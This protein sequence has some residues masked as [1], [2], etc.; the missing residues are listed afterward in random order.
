M[1]VVAAYP[2]EDAVTGNRLHRLTLNF[3]YSLFFLHDNAFSFFLS[4][5][6]SPIFDDLFP[7]TVSFSAP[8]G[9]HRRGRRRAV[10]RWWT[11]LIIRASLSF[12]IFM[13]LWIFFFV[14]FLVYQEV[15]CCG[16]IAVELR[17]VLWSWR[18][19]SMFWQLILVGTFL[20][21][22]NCVLLLISNKFSQDLKVGLVWNNFDG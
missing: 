20:D 7:D 2:L 18:N 15:K 11:L 9:P 1:K 3:L 16:F 12:G 21:F 6:H 22:V 13:F 4:H 17:F 8:A 5:I 10:V 19:L 14:F